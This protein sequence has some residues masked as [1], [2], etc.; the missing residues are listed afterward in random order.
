M[1]NPPEWRLV[2]TWMIIEVFFGRSSHHVNRT[3][4]TLPSERN[5]SYT[6]A[7]FVI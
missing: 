3:G 4:G 7:L 6:L 2:S 1:F 5:I